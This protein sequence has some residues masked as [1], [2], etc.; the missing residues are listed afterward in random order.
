[1]T[2]IRLASGEV[3]E[4]PSA[5]V[6]LG[7]NVGVSGVWKFSG[8]LPG[9]H[10]VITALMHGNEV[11][12]AVAIAPL[13][14]S[15]PHIERGS[16]TI[17]FLN[18]KAYRLI[19]DETKDECRW[20]DEDMNRVWGRVVAG[21]TPPLSYECQRAREVLPH[22]ADADMLLDLHSMH[23]AGPALGLTGVATK[24]VALAQALGLPELIVRDQGH[25]AGLRL[26]DLV[27]WRDPT[28]APVAMLLECGYHFDGQ[29][30]LTARSAVEAMLACGTLTDAAGTRTA[31]H[32]I[33]DVTAAV[34]ISTDRF[35]FEREFE[36]MQVLPQAG[37]LIARDGDAPVRT[38]YANTVLV[39]PAPSRYRRK[40]MTAVRFARIAGPD[41]SPCRSA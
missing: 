39:M 33:V 29:T 28:S 32:R 13:V 41:E 30:L 27:P 12:G 16:L 4:L 14:T 38:P 9:P 31:R 7:T 23:T 17:V 37:T 35:A 34:T 6:V 25:A 15:P 10:R 3:I 36:N 24:N 1:M 18:L 5:D 22:I 20:Y 40:G 19:S 11:C 2:T 21:A 26:I 8:Q